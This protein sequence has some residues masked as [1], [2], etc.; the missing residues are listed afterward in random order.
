[1]INPL[2]FY[3]TYTSYDGIRLVAIS[4]LIVGAVMAHAYIFT[5]HKRVQIVNLVSWLSLEILFLGSITVAKE[6]FGVRIDLFAQVIYFA[7]LFVQALNLMLLTDFFIE[8]KRG[9]KFDI[10]H[11]SRKHFTFSLNLGLLILLTVSSGIV[12]IESRYIWVFIIMGINLLL[13]LVVTHFAVR[14]QLKEPFQFTK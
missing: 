2:D 4:L 7:M 1:M 13:Q 12:F 14:S 10:D 3:K 6:L 5:K 11:V 9:K 8:E